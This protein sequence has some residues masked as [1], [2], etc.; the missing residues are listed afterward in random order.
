MEQYAGE[1]HERSYGAHEPINRWRPVFKFGGIIA[2]SQR[3]G[4]QG[5]NDE[6]GIIQADRDSHDFAQWNLLLTIHDRTDLM[7]QPLTIAA[8]EFASLPGELELQHEM[9]LP[10]GCSP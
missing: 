8:I 5:K 2:F 4:D 6:P 3:P 10:E 9:V 7:L 1:Q